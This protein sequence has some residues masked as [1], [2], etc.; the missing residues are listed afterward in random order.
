MPP[1]R[2]INREAAAAPKGASS[3][4]GTAERPAVALL[5]V[6]HAGQRIL[7]LRGQKALVD[8]D[9]AELYGVTTKR[10]NQQT[11]RNSGGF[12]PISCSS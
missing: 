6:A 2:G 11:R 7:L 10:L 5:G 12:R 8:A 1:I 4:P 9:L 3:S